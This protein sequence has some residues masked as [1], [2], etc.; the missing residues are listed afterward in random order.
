MTRRTRVFVSLGVAL[1]VGAA[2]AAWILSAVGTDALSVPFGGERYDL[3][4]F[5]GPAARP[6][7]FA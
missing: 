5:H 6:T 4:K 1:A 2:V 3:L 7:D